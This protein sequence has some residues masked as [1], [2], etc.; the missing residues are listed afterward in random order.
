[1]NT[2]VIE[3][4]PLLAD[5]RN[6]IKWVHQTGQLD[7][8]R[9]KKAHADAATGARVEPFIQQMMTCYAEASLVICRAG[10]STLAEL[11][12]VGRASI[13]VPLPTASDDHQAVNARVFAEAGAARVAPQKATDPVVFAEMIRTLLRD[14]ARIQAME[15]AARS[16]AKPEAARSA[17]AS[18]L[19]A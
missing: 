11:A 8:E 15:A 18:I 1:M 3:A 12:M 10:S 14:P 19:S 4:L 2:L 7:F 13:L 16:L 5:L 17:V 9:V 6:E